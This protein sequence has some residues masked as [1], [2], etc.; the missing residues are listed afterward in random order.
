MKRLW[1]VRLGRHGEMESHAVEHSELV[2]VFKPGNLGGATTRDAILQILRTAYVDRKPKSQLHFAAQ[3]NQFCNEMHPG[4]LV[5]VPFR[6]TSQIGIAE[7]TGPFHQIADSRPCLPVRWLKL[8]L[9]R[10]SFR[11]DLLYSFGAFMTVCEIRRNDALRR[12][13]AVVKTGKDPGFEAGLAIGTKKSQSFADAVLTIAEDE[14]AQ[15]SELDLPVFARDQIERRIASAFTGH[16]FTELIAEILKAQG[17]VVNVSPPGPDSGIDIVAGRGS[18]GFEGPRLVVQVKSGNIVA[19]QPTLQSLIGAVQDAHAD[20]GLLVCWGGFKSTVK[21]RR[22]ELFF[23]IRLWD[24]TRVVDAL[25]EIYDRLP[26]EFR[27][28][29]P[30]RRI[31]TLVLEDEDA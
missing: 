20:H 28:D 30:L 24:R 12:V 8:D 26:E 21:A 25:L 6:T 15:E 2:I 4:D 9:P 3:L 27:A 31:W 7:I 13:Q 23:R 10:D 11:Q 5:V 14:T 1:L 22:N 29:L 19:D 16:R 17:Y 18:L